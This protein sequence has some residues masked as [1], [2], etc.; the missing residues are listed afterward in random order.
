MLGIDL[1]GSNSYSRIDV[2]D[3]TG[4]VIQSKPIE[5]NFQ[6]IEMEINKSGVFIVQ[7]SSPLGNR[8]IEKVVLFN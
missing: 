5:D 7:L 8:F 1:R 6:I 2:L 3:I 4:R